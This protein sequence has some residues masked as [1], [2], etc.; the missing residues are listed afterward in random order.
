[1]LRGEDLASAVTTTD[2][3]LALKLARRIGSR[4]WASA[5]AHNVAEAARIVGDWELAFAELGR[6]AEMST[7]DDLMI[8]PTALMMLD[9]ERGIDISDTDA[10]ERVRARADGAR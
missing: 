10:A 9:A 1:M 8:V 7:G 6:E 3:A 4:P 2:R 5:A